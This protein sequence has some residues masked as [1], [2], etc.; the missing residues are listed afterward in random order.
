MTLS[1]TLAQHDD[2]LRVEALTEA[3]EALNDCASHCL[4]CADACLEEDEVEPMVRCIRS[5]LDCATIC[6]ATA[7]VL[8][9]AGA[10]GAPWRDQVQVAIKM[11]EV[12]AEECGSHDHGHCQE[13]AQACRRANEA[14]KSLLGDA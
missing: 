8:S 12:C 9:R 2:D 13:C 1:S 14:C 11:T 6:R 10:S 3:I 7:D 5:D 4:A